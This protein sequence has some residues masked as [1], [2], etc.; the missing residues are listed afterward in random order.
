MSLGKPNI[1]CLCRMQSGKIPRRK[2]PK[3]NPR[4]QWMGIANSVLWGMTAHLLMAL[5]LALFRLHHFRSHPLLALVMVWLLQ[6]P[7]HGLQISILKGMGGILDLLLGEQ[8]ILCHW[9]H[10]GQH[11]ESDDNHDPRLL[12][13]WLLTWGFLKDCLWMTVSP[14]TCLPCHLW[15]LSGIKRLLSAQNLRAR[16]MIQSLPLYWIG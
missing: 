1:I 7:D 4:M 3:L 12:R 13:S 8:M 16:M 11:L 6:S 15:I 9:D 2:S 5:L 10:L 14:M